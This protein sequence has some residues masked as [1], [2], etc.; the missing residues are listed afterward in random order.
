M[1]K[2]KFSCLISEENDRKFLLSSHNPMEIDRKFRQDGQDP[3]PAEG[4]GTSFLTYNFYFMN[5]FRVRKFVFSDTNSQI[6]I[7]L[8]PPKTL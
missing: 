1:L 2:S 5:I 4:F 8:H 7:K 6:L 3:G